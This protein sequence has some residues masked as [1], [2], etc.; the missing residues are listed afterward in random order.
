MNLFLFFIF[1]YLILVN[2]FRKRVSLH[3]KRE[4]RRWQVNGVGLVRL[5]A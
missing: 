4:D 2:I 5:S 3:V 1:F